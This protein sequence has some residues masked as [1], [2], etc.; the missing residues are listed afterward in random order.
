MDRRFAH[1]LLDNLENELLRKTVI[2]V[3]KAERAHFNRHGTVYDPLRYLKKIELLQSGN[4]HLRN[5]KV[6]IDY[7]R[8]RIKESGERS[9]VNIFKFNSAPHYVVPDI[10][11]FN[12][13]RT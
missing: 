12:S 6:R 3:K 11:R 8:E 10:R 1:I 9:D 2:E 13:F 4:F 7:L 5:L